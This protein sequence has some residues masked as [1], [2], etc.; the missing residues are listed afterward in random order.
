MK[1]RRVWIAAGFVVSVLGSAT[2][3]HGGTVSSAEQAAEH[4]EKQLAKDRAYGGPKRL[5]CLS[6]EGWESEPEERPRVFNVEI[7]EVH[8]GKCARP[9]VDPNSA[10]AVGFFTVLEDGTI[11]WDDRSGDGLRS[12]GEFLESERRAR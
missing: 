8:Q 6:F 4:L 3:A 7:R 12:Y 2:V 9:G 11:L 5:E 10:P 1:S